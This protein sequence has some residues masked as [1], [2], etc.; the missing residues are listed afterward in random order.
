MC[1]YYV[2]FL[3]LKILLSTPSVLSYM[4]PSYEPL[5]NFS[6]WLTCQHCLIV[7]NLIVFSD[8]PIGYE[9]FC[10]SE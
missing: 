4:L 8:K 3:T 1:T 9:C 5:S 2:L 7:R 10:I 6:N